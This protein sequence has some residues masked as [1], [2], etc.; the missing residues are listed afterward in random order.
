MVT[1]NSNLNFLR[2]TLYADTPDSW[3]NKMRATVRTTRCDEY[4]DIILEE[5]LLDYSFSGEV[6]NIRYRCSLLE[7]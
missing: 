5:S 7:P 2:S 1:A 4:S 3:D 6:S